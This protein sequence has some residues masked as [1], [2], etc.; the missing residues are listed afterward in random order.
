MPVDPPVDP[1]VP[2]GRP[3]EE[4]G[5]DSV[6]SRRSSSARRVAVATGSSVA[7]ASRTAASACS[8]C[9]LS[10]SPYFSQS[11][12]C[13]QSEEKRQLLEHRWLHED[14]VEKAEVARRQ[15]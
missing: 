10:P 14:R 13:Q 11:L 15:Q 4:E 1:P 2:D 5:A 8:C 7:S 12:A 3:A 9:R 6:T